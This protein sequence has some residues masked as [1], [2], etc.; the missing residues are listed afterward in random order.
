VPIKKA[1][2]HYA[3][4]PVFYAKMISLSTISIA[5]AR[6]LFIFPI[7]SKAFSAFSYSVIPRACFMPSMSFSKRSCAC[8]SFS[9][10]GVESAACEK[11][12]VCNLAVL[13]QIP[14]VPLSE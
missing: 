6:M 7:H 9:K 4:L 10:V 1:A 3:L 11:I 12:G 5:Q 2:E 13:P 8:P 14:Q